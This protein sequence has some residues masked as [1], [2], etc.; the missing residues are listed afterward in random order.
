MGGSGAGVGNAGEVRRWASLQPFGKAHC[1]LRG[2][3]PTLLLFVENQAS[4]G[5]REAVTGLFAVSV[6]VGHVAQSMTMRS[7][8]TLERAGVFAIVD[9]GE[10]ALEDA[11]DG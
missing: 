3:E 10:L 4:C 7:P 9:S 5:Q 6:G 1:D 8:I 2:G 11:L